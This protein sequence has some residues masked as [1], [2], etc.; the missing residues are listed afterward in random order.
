MKQND[1]FTKR[2]TL[3]P[4]NTLTCFDSAHTNS[5]YILKMKELTGIYKQ[6]SELLQEDLTHMN[7][8]INSQSEEIQNEIEPQILQLKQLLQKQVVEYNLEMQDEIV[9]L[10]NIRNDNLDLE[11]EIYK[12]QQSLT[13][14][15]DHI[16]QQ[17]LQRK[18]DIKFS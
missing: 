6:E 12:L 2:E 5:L 8:L 3:R 4:I 1:V 10:E 9:Q 17:V 13:Q 15:D 14:L 16:G 18:Y 7:K 11:K